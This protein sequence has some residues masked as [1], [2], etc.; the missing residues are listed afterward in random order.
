[1]KRQRMPNL[2]ESELD[3]LRELWPRSTKEEILK[4]FP[5][6]N[7]RSLGNQMYKRGVKCEIERNRLGT[8]A[9]LL[10]DTHEAWYWLGFIMAD[11]HISTQNQV[12]AMV[13]DKDVDHLEKLAKFLSTEVKY[14]YGKST[15]RSGFTST[16]PLVRITVADR[17][18]VPKL[19]D[20]LDLIHTDKTY[21][22]ISLKVVP[23]EFRTSFLIGFIDGD[24]SISENGYLRIENHKSWVSFHLEIVDYL[25]DFHFLKGKPETS[26]IACSR[27]AGKK[28]Y[29]Y[30]KSTKLP[31]L[32]R[33]WSRYDRC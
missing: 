19:K 24:G 14:P 33:K 4:E 9:P 10:E 6:R 13:S 26:L 2:T 12:V 1:M 28:L 5:G 3:R 32:G 11:G 30:A 17:V 27:G 31:Y 7:Y 29:E 22:P 18:L 25:P 23:E 21:N 16:T 8:V 15:D 20:K